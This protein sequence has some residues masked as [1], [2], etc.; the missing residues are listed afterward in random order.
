MNELI[1]SLQTN[2]DIKLLM[3]QFDR[4]DFCINKDSAYIDKPSQLFL[5]QTI[6]A[7]HMHAKAIEYLKPV[8]N[9]GASILDIGSGSGY[10]TAC[11]GEA[12]KV[13]HED[14]AFRGKVIGIDIVPELVTYSSIIIQG[15]YSKLFKYKRNFKILFK[16]GKLGHPSKKNEEIYDGIHIGAAC[17]SIPYYLFQQLK[18]EGILVIPLKKNETDLIFTIVRKDKNGNIYLTEKGAVRYVP[19][20]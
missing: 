15:K 7:P 13:Y 14:E 9:P 11:F 19:L 6:S 8:L 4:K 1:N 5:G 17:E 10:L 18:K 12:V 16:D 3:K 2:D 20:I